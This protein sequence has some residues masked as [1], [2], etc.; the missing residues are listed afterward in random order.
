MSKIYELYTCSYK[1]AVVYVGEGLKGRHKHC[2][3]GCSHVYELNRIHFQEGE[4]VLDVNV[5]EET[6]TKSS[7]SKK[8]RFLIDKYRPMFNKNFTKNHNPKDLM[9]EGKDFRYK[10]KFY[11]YNTAKTKKSLEKYENLCNDFIDYFGY[12]EIETG[13]IKIASSEH[14]LKIKLPSLASLS[15]WLREPRTSGK[16][17]KTANSVFFQYFKNVLGVDLRDKTS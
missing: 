3:S 11:G 2:N 8:E 10:I 17:N 14:Y 12:S 6:T 13:D 5:I 15:R 9:L 16:I 1:G 4:Q 7:V